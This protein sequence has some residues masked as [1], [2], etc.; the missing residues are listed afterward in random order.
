MVHSLEWA[1]SSPR[2]PIVQGHF[3][4]HTLH[5]YHDDSLYEQREVILC[6]R[7]VEYLQYGCGEHDEGYVEGEAGRCTSTIDGE[8][9]IGVGGQWGEDQ[10]R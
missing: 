2:R 6:S 10:T 5:T 9:L 7:P 1:L 4:K 3:Q 8:D